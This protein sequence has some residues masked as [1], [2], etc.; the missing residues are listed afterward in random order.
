MKCPLMLTGLVRVCLSWCRLQHGQ[1]CGAGRA[2]HPERRAQLPDR[3]PPDQG[4]PLGPC[5]GQ[6]HRL[7]PGGQARRVR[8]TAL[9]RSCEYTDG[10]PLAKLSQKPPRRRIWGLTL[11]LLCRVVGA[12]AIGRL[13]M[14]RLKVRCAETVLALSCMRL[15]LQARPSPYVLI[16]ASGACI[17]ATVWAHS[18]ARMPFAD[19]TRPV[20]PRAE[21]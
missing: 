12:G 18:T 14:Q 4:R 5:G 6:Q 7:R 10:T 21:L 16:N 2:V 13:V 9:T 8:S 3:P 1:H 19:A 11:G 17:A 20:Q 15:L